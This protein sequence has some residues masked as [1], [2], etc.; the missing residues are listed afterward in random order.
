MKSLS[1]HLSTKL[2]ALMYTITIMSLKQIATIAFHHLTRH[3]NEQS[4]RKHLIKLHHGTLT[5]GYISKR[6]YQKIYTLNTNELDF[7]RNKPFHK[8]IINIVP[9]ST[10]IASNR[11]WY[12]AL[13][14]RYSIW[15]MHAKMKID[16]DKGFQYAIWALFLLFRPREQFSIFAP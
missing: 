2:L 13:H 11:K 7:L 10:N 9:V 15:N 12:Q 1:R 3:L 4:V 14:F 8:V 6:R 5:S 16:S